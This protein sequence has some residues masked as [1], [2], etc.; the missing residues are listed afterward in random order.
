MPPG[1]RNSA[2]SWDSFLHSLYLSGRCH[3]SPKL[4]S[5]SVNIYWDRKG[6]RF[7]EK[8]HFRS[9]A[10]WDPTQHC[11]HVRSLQMLG[12]GKRNTAVPAHPSRGFETY[13]PETNLS[14]EVESTPIHTG[15]L[16]AKQGNP[17][18]SPCI[19]TAG[20]AEGKGRASCE[21]EE[22]RKTL[23][24]ALPL[25]KEGQQRKDMLTNYLDF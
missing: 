7:W 2:A 3:P 25:K 22:T 15:T 24:N 16:P 11:T 19:C 5:I 13:T 23:G 1:P 18:A 12:K 17:T 8:Q 10:S 4:N 21:R 14:G 6:S 9:H 20:T